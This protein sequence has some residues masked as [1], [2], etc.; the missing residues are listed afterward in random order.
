LGHYL[1][2]A[3]ALIGIAAGVSFFFRYHDF[4]RPDLT[5]SRLNSLSADTVKLL[6]D[7]KPKHPIHIEAFISPV[8]PEIY[9]ESRQDLISRLH[10]IGKQGGDDIVVQIYDAAPF[11]ETARR[12]EEEFGIN[13]KTVRAKSRGTWIE[14]EIL[15]GAV[16]RSGL[17]KVV[18]PFFDLG[19]PV[20]YELVRSILTIAQPK[21]KRL[22]VV[23]TDAG[24]FG[25]FGSRPQLIIEELKKQYEVEEVDPNRKIVDSEDAAGQEYDV[26]LVVQ[27]S[28]L[29]PMQLPNLLDAIKAGIPTAIFE[30][31]FPAW[32]T[33]APGTSQ[34]KRPPMQMM[35]FQQ[36]RPQPKCDIQQLWNLLDAKMLGRPG[37]GD[38]PF[39]GGGFDASIVWQAYNPYPPLRQRLSITNEWIF[40]SVDAPGAA[41]SFNKEQKI[42]SGM[43]ELLFLMPGAI[44]AIEGSPLTFTS[45]V[46][47]GT[48]T[49]TIAFNDLRENVQDAYELKSRERPTGTQYTLA[50]RIGGK[51]QEAEMRS[52]QQN[53]PGDGKEKQKK[54]SKHTPGEV[55]V[56][57]VMDIDLLE[58][59][60]L[61]LRAEPIPEL[62]LHFQNVPFVLNILDDLAGDERFLD[63]RKREQEFRRLSKVEEV[64]NVYRQ[65]T[66]KAIEEYRKNY[67]EVKDKTQKS[68]DE[69]MQEFQDEVDKMRT[70]EGFDPKQLEAAMTRLALKE[71][72]E[73]RRKAVK[74]LANKAERDRNIKQSND[75][76]ELKT[77]KM[78]DKIKLLA[79][80][81]PPIPPL[82]LAGLV[83]LQRRS[84]ETEGIAKSRLR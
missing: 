42:I 62:D 32:M 75:E 41:D 9:V 10:E 74:D 8:V 23:T 24:L 55:D 26:L 18:V 37:F 68:R 31:P 65:E 17:D 78:Q 76:L 64:L 51:L 52:L 6:A 82:L 16:F 30:D 33:G 79:V 39:G 61:R 49:G 53:D 38:G 44:S 73:S 71:Q 1:I 19:I 35:M 36:Q 50:A 63:I 28:S 58:S 14:S 43:K 77:R 2:R 4:L 15:L 29:T 5:L 60:F 66:E 11:S 67:R 69:S 25:S 84:R 83:F 72:I 59:T 3:M 34:P 22:G 12:A 56:V 54:T 45:L 40:A 48:S 81:L 57:V 13:R 46:T 20:E 70:K 47:T 7:L 80:C 21:R 27:P